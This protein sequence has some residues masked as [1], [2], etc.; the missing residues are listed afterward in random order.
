[1]HQ[2][3]NLCLPQN[4]TC[5]LNPVEYGDP[6]DQSL[7]IQVVKNSS[8]SPP[9]PQPPRTNSILRNR[10]H[11]LTPSRALFGEETT[12][13]LHRLSDLH[14]ENRTSKRALNVPP[15]K[16][17][18]VVDKA[19][20]SPPRTGTATENP[21]PRH[22]EK[23]RN[24]TAWRNRE[25]PSTK[26]VFS[27]TPRTEGRGSRGWRRIYF[28]NPDLTPDRDFHDHTRPK[29]P[30]IHSSST[31]LR[32]SERDS[33][34]SGTAVA[35]APRT[36]R[37]EARRGRERRGEARKKRAATGGGGPEPRRPPTTQRDLQLGTL[38]KNVDIKED[39]QL[40]YLETNWKQK[41]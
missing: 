20:D 30:H 3:W 40:N 1:M 21:T 32:S 23:H 27:P 15:P 37:K 41:I 25:A 39:G 11:P 8:C 19:D 38:S 10:V 24:A 13:S 22:A 14:Q 7:K 28:R 26:R 2:S 4:Q 16:E 34:R 5:R 33:T 17:E 29:E 12:K 31:L 9:N 36:L 35:Q 6:D 18:A